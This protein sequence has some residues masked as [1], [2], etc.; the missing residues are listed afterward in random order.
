MAT[1]LR[2]TTLT[3]PTAPLGPENPLPALRLPREVHRIDEP[4][5][6]TLPADM[7][8]QAAYEPLS[9]VLPVRLRDGYGRGRAAAGLDA[10]VLENDRLRA[11]VLPGLGGRVHSL[12]HKPTGRE[13]LYRNPVLQPADFGLS[14]AWF[15]GGIE[16][17]IG[18]TG[19]TTLACAPLHAARVPAPDGGEMVRLWEW[20]RL[21]DLPFQVDLWLPEDSDFLYVG[22]RIRNP[23][24]QPAPVYW[25]S[26]IA[27]PEAAGT[28]VLAPADAAWHF[29]YSRTLRHVPVPEWDGTDR[30][31]PLHGDYP[32]D[33]FYDLPADARPWIASLDREGHGLVQTSTDQL[34]GRKLFLW[35]AGPGG[36]R[37]QGWLTEPDTPGYAEIQAGLART[38]LEHVRLEAGE[39][40]A[41]LEAY[42]PLAADPAAVHG[43]DWAAARREVEARLESAA[44]RAAVAAAYAAWRPYADAEPGERLATGSGWG[45]LEVERGGYRLPGTPFHPDTLG[46]PQEPWRRLLRTGAFPAWAAGESPADP[47]CSLTAPAWRDLLESAPATAAAEYHLGVAQWHAG[48]RAQATRSWERSLRCTETPWALRCLAV[49]DTAAGHPARAA[50]RLLRA[51]GLILAEGRDRAPALAGAQDARAAVGHALGGAALADPAVTDPVATDP[52][53][54]EA[55][56]TEAA[57]AALGRES[58]AALLAVGRA[59][60]ARTVLDALRPAVRKRG[61]FRLLMAQVLLAQGDA[62]AARAI[63]DGG[64]EV[65]DLREGDETLSDTWYAIAERIVAGDGEPV[66]DDVRERA[67]AEHPLPER[68]EFRMRPA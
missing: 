13:L 58:V 39:E 29:G 27:V 4:T 62:V 28:R 59:E 63:F 52:V 8:R 47:G 11:T 37:W 66:T 56:A 6:A 25:W 21:R 46:E 1:S 33:Y 61:R 31:Y 53:A 19:H 67:R 35:G 42:G 12:H 10:L 51:V 2:R 54:T 41:W 20:E 34:R 7:A 43:A 14:G 15:S 64:F 68:Y 26:N 17:N 50:D 48:D 32:A 30:T 22:V 40:F 36:R 55:A 9:S 49:A 3:L 38:Q 16:W 65:A 5:R 57:E 45:A 23:H 18:A 44:P 24:H 60:D